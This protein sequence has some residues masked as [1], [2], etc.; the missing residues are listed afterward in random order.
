MEVSIRLKMFSSDLSKES[1]DENKLAMML[2]EKLGYINRKAIAFVSV[3]L[4]DAGVN[5]VVMRAGF[6]MIL[7]CQNVYVQ[8]ECIGQQKI[9]L[10]EELRVKFSAVID[11]LVAYC[12]S[13]AV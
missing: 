4:V 8:I 13:E 12:A 5:Y 2:Y 10:S 9:P 1:F 3:P 11:R 7:G 6:R